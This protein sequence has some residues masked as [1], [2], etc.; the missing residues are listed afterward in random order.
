MPR[1]GSR[2]LGIDHLKRIL[3]D[4]HH[5]QSEQIHLDDAHVGAV[6][7][8]P[9]DDDA[10]GHRGVFERDD[11]VEASLANHH[12]AGMLA[13]MPRQILD[14]LPETAEDLDGRVLRVDARVVQVALQRLRGIDPFELIHHLRQGVDEIRLHREHLPDLAR[15]APAA[16]GDHVGGHGSAQPAVFLID[17]LNDALASI[18]A[19]QI[20]IDIG[21][22]A[23]LFRQEPL[24]E[25]V[26]ADRIDGGDAEAVAHGAVGGRPASL[27]ENPLLAAEVHD[28]PD[29]QE[30]ARQVELFDQVQ[31]TLDLP[32]HMG[33]D[34]PIAIARAG[35][36][37]LPQERRHRLTCGHGVFRE[38]IAEIRHRVGEAVGQFAGRVERLR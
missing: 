5:S 3:Q 35:L 7:L 32:R 19:R 21:P 8:V 38:A 4:R 2:I 25:Q 1:T 29:D 23:A 34:R 12:A 36:R 16:I 33:L 26:H 18:A 11:L 22:F 10:V 14:L 37:D 24:E 6:V 15:R 13:E 31:L 28:V 17:V 9:L 30:I 20:E 27:H